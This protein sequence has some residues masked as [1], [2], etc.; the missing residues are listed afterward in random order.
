M[1]ATPQK[2]FEALTAA[3]DAAESASEKATMLMQHLHAGLPLGRQADLVDRAY[4]VIS[5]MPTSSRAE[6]QERARLLGTLA[7][8]ATRVEAAL[9]AATGQEDA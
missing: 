9:A 2:I 5:G 1:K 4:E 7:T 8:H 3:A 6:R